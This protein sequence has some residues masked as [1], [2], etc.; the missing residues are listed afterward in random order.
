MKISDVKSYGHVFFMLYSDCF[1]AKGITRF[2]ILDITNQKLH[3][4]DNRFLD[5]LNLLKTE[6]ISQVVSKLKKQEEIDLFIE[7]VN[8]LEK[9][10]LGM[11][12]KD[13]S[14]F[15]EIE[16]TWDSPSV[17]TNAIIDIKEDISY[18][19]TVLLQLDELLCSQ[20]QIRF[21][22]ETTWDNL[23]YLLPLVSKKSFTYIQLFIKYTHDID[24]LINKLSFFLEDNSSLFVLIYNYP[25]NSKNFKRKNTQITILERDIDFI[26]DCGFITTEYFIKPTIQS[27]MENRLYN[28]CLNRKISIDIDGYIKN[29]PAF[30]YNYGNVKDVLL[31]NV[32][33]LTEFR[34]FW[35]LNKEKISVC[36]NC[37][38]SSICTDCRA[39]LS[40]PKDFYSKPQKCSY[41]PQ[42]SKWL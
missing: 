19:E 8:Y 28:G 21:H 14:L 31:K 35:N 4:C 6:T 10:D 20:L 39:F 18:I 34:F 5:I 13:I 17:I 36:E 33:N 30:T 29:C 15:P 32:V 9:N 40:D 3:L 22:E 24:C 12:V 26:N 42:M 27:Y 37:E 38:L 41:D 11:F 23:E 7:F 16:I 2:S 1:V 25:K